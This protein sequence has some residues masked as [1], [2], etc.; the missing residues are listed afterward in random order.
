MTVS[1]SGFGLSFGSR[2]NSPAGGRVT[3]PLVLPEGG[4]FGLL[5]LV[6]RTIRRCR[7]AGYG[8][9]RWNTS[10]IFMN[11]WL[12]MRLGREVVAHQ[13]LRE[14]NR[15]LDLKSEPVLALLDELATYQAVYE[16][17]EREYGPTAGQPRS[18][19]DDPQDVV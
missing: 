8:P 13:L 1:D 4:N 3:P 10:R 9:A 2:D 17:F 18:G 14:F 6:D 12:S 16:T 11:H 19:V 15:F 5:H 7:L